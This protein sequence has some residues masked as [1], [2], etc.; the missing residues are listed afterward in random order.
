M[1]KITNTNN[2]D[3]WEDY[4]IQDKELD[5]LYNHLLEIETPQ[6]S[7]DL[8]RALIHERILK[9][10][11]KL[12][13]RQNKGVE[14]FLPK[15]R[16]AIGQTVAF[17]SLGWK[18]GT[19]TNIRDGVNPDIPPFE[20][21]EVTFPDG[22][23]R[24]F[25]SGIEDHKLNQ[26][27]PIDDH[28]DNL[29]PDRVYQAYGI[30]L[31]NQL[32]EILYERDEIVFIAGSWF[33]RSLLVDVNIGYLNMAEALLEME[34]GNPLT[35]KNILDQIELP[36]DVNQN[37][38]EF[39]LN[40]ALQEDGRFDEVGPSGEV[41]WALKRLEP[42]WV[43]NPP[44]YLRFG[45]VQIDRSQIANFLP[46]LDHEI[47]DEY[48]TY[49]TQSSKDETHV[50]LIFPHWY[51]GTIPLTARTSHIFPSAL[52]SPRVRFTFRDADTGQ[53][54]PGWVVRPSKYI[55]GLQEW[56]RTQGVIPGT[57]VKLA[58]GD[59]PGEVKV[60]YERKRPT[61]EWIRTALVGTDG[62]IVFAM[63]KQLVTTHYNERMAIAI[64]DINAMSKFW[65]AGNKQ[66]L[67]LEQTIILMMK[68]LAK[69]NPQGHVHLEEL[70]AAVNLTRRCPPSQIL[71][72]ILEKTWANHLGDLYFRL[73]EPLN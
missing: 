16:Y 73:Q 30:R 9:Q 1:V 52:V 64:P 32:E 46:L 5:F 53:T 15:E 21:I 47:I 61:R 23:I 11:K 28:D 18:T 34:N 62:G 4:Q 56:Y 57:I 38:T 36:T 66:R 68:E 37:L 13:G 54:M 2:T 33:P 35:T 71:S 43:Q 69:L 27:I 49:P 58:S 39:S 50:C 60:R 3:F 41:Q 67:N 8:I 7:H 42:E 17:A 63:L 19:I 40:L 59:A 22:E 55:F 26:P 44:I 51:C 6:T 70:Y 48:E 45:T 65:E 10:K 14:V 25:A 29:D 72:V 24:R 31:V 12:E 20:V